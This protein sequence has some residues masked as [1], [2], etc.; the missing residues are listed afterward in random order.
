MKCNSQAP[1][2][3]RHV[4]C[5]ISLTNHDTHTHTH[6]YTPGSTQFRV[7]GVGYSSDGGIVHA[8]GDVTPLTPHTAP[9]LARLLECGK[10]CNNAVINDGAA[11][12]QATEAALVV[13][14]DKMGLSDAAKG[15]KRTAELPF[16][17]STK[18][19]AVRAK[20]VGGAYV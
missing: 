12:G 15:W 17:S 9:Q 1:T 4:T 8:D 16:S 13:A 5:T 19:M 7:T 10:V 3:K 18:W 6:R 2:A 14:A 11:V 20:P